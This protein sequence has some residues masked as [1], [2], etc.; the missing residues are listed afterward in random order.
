MGIYDP[1]TLRFLGVNDVAVGH[2]GY[3]RDEFPGMR[4]TNLYAP[5]GL[6]PL[7]EAAHQVD[8][9]DQ[10]SLWRRRLE[11]GRLIDLEIVAQTIDFAGRPARVVLAHDVTERRRAARNLPDS[12]QAL[13]SLVQRLQSAQDE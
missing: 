11:V 5:G 10:G 12:R 6:P 8:D 1:A 2:C 3:P 13:C 4:L 7:A 9:E